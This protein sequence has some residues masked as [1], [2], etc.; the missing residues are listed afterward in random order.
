MSAAPQTIFSNQE[1]LIPNSTVKEID[2][3]RNHITQNITNTNKENIKNS[4][5]LQYDI[6]TYNCRSLKQEWRMVQL[7]EELKN[8]IWRV[9][10]LAEV[11]REGEGLV[12]LENGDNFYYNGEEGIIGGTGFL[13]NGKFKDQKIIKLEKFSKR[14][15]SLILEVQNK[16]V[17]IVQVHAPHC[18]SPEEEWEIFYANL[19]EA[20][21]RGNHLSRRFC[22]GDFNSRVGKCI[23]EKCLGKFGYGM[24]NDKGERLIEFAEGNNLRIMNTFYKKDDED[25]W[26]WIHPNKKTK[27]EI[28]FIMTSRWDMVKNVEVVKNVDVNSD[29]RAVGAHIVWGGKRKK[30]A[31]KRLEKIYKSKELI[32]KGFEE[33]LELKLL[34]DVKKENTSDGE[35][36]FLNNKMKE[37]LEEIGREDQTKTNNCRNF[38]NKIKRLMEKRRKYKLKGTENKEYIE[39]S[40]L[41]RKEITE[42]L[43]TR[44]IE[45]VVNALENGGKLNEK[46]RVKDIIVSL[47]DKEGNEIREKGS[48]LEII[49]EFYEDLYG[50]QEDRE[51]RTTQEPAE[52]Q[53]IMKEEVE[54]AIKNTKEGK[55]GGMDRISMEMLKAGGE[56]VIDYLTHIFNKCMKEGKLPAEWYKAKLIILHKKGDKKDLKNYRPLSLLSVEYKVLSKI[57]TNRLHNH[58][59]QY[60][61]IEQAGFRKNFS[62]LDHIFVL[63]DLIAKAKEYNFALYILFVD[64]EKAFDQIKSKKILEMLIIRGV[65]Q[66]IINILQDVYEKSKLEVELDGE[67]AEIEVQKGVRQG[68][69]AS[70]ILFIGVLQMILDQM[71]WDNLGLN[72][73]GVALNKLE[74]ADDVVLIGKNKNE[75]ETMIVTLEDKCKEYGLK[76]NESKCKIM[77]VEKEESE[78]E[79]VQEEEEFFKIGNMRVGRERH[80]VY[81]GQQISIE[82]QWSEIRKRC[83]IGWKTLLKNRTIFKSKVKIE[84]KRKLWEMTVL[85]ALTY[86]CETW[87]LSNKVI[88]KLRTTVR[89]MERYIIGKTR[90]DRI[91]NVIIR[92]KTGF[93]DII[94]VVL[95]RKWKWAGHIARCKDNRW[96]KTIMDWYPR[97]KKRDR[98][99]PS[100]K[101]DK[102][103]RKVCGGVTWRRVADQRGEWKRMG[104]VYREVWLDQVE[105]N[106]Y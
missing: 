9:I 23:K 20:A 87:T 34:H 59:D 41:V 83:A 31:Q 99:R 11:R 8:V 29:H 26:T 66:K 101:W 85:P 89:A 74:F 68:D 45:R 18:L 71:E 84:L 72:I 39:I 21:E 38:P 2:D 24:R 58:L 12:T 70:P 75:L 5:L 13:I 62:T 61:S 33:R 82:G 97:E 81:L 54:W 1:E 44:E 37:T 64:F 88:N 86:A 6:I 55:S 49:K 80:F 40:K 25:K 104:E 56:T 78:G 65:D 102:E 90:R 15:S 48:M 67:V 91:R 42:W 69:S 98:G 47:K 94:K 14:I 76:I 51:P 63:N 73:N 43:E 46:P 32:K 79:Y 35:V 77:I 28:D 53:E 60:L 16:K 3:L 30:F 17:H 95:E 93:K 96:T 27:T 103:M 7:Q 10:G 36:T 106:L 100:D 57:I 19:L 92:R 4:D 105:E 50:D 52:W 22:I